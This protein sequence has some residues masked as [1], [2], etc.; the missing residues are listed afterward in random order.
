MG[1]R[2]VG[3]PQW[4]NLRKDM[5]KRHTA[6]LWICFLRAATGYAFTTVFA[7]FAFTFVSRP[8]IM[9]TPALVAGFTR[10]L[11]RHR[12]GMVKMPFFFTSLEAISTKLLSSSEQAF[13]F[14]SC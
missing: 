4:T 13:T 1:I 6:L 7:G 14:I 5:E 10:V 11:I 2:T 9:R 12:P 3:F 8:N